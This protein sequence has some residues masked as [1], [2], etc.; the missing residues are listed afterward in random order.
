MTDRVLHATVSDVY[1]YYCWWFAA[2]SGHPERRDPMKRFAPVVVL[3]LCVYV[4]LRAV[5]YKVIIT[6][7]K[8]SAAVAAVVGCVPHRLS[9][10]ARDRFDSRFMTKRGPWCTARRHDNIVLYVCICLRAYIAEYIQH[11]N[12]VY[13]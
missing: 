7:G 5:M 10:R 2:L 13:V 6:H 11:N 9:R 12:A 3:A 4:Y 1:G 8:S